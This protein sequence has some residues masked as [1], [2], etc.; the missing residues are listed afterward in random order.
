MEPTTRTT[1]L[2]PPDTPAQTYAAIVGLFLLV[3]GILSLVIESVSFG[4]I[5][6]VVAQ[7]QFLIWSVSGWTTILWIVMGALGLLAMARLDA[8]RR[9]A[10][11]AGVLFAVIAIWGFIDGNNVVGLVAADT[12]NNITHAI[13]G[14][15]GLLVAMLPQGMQRAAADRDALAPGERGETRRPGSRRTTGLGHR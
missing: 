4:T 7:P 10:M 9:Y 15:L 2:E 3:L 1:T 13:I 12:T 5:G 8:A 6:S 14:G 11:F